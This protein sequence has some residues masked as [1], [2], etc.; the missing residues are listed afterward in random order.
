MSQ[1]QENDNNARLQFYSGFKKEGPPKEAC[2]A[3]Y[4]GTK[5]K[6]ANLAGNSINKCFFSLVKFRLPRSH[7]PRVQLPEKYTHQ[8]SVT[9][10]HG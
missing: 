8:P 6:R 4:S 7:L 3:V 10:Y 1:I 2:L 5:R 9:N